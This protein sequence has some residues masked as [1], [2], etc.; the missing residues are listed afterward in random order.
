[1]TDVQLKTA[2]TPEPARMSKVK[3][4]F[5]YV[6]VGGLVALALTAVIA[7]LIGEF[8]EVIQRVMV[9]IF[10]FFAHILFIL[11]VIWA[12]KANQVGKTILPTTVVVLALANMITATLA[13]WDILTAETAWR[14]LGLYFL[15]LA[16][17]FTVIGVLKLRIDQK[18]VSNLTY[19]SAG[20]LIVMTVLLAPWVLGF[21]EVLDP[22]YFRGVG[23]LA[24]VITTAFLVAV[25]FRGI[26]VSRPGYI[27]PIAQL[28]PHVYGGLLAI[29]ITLGVITGMV[30]SVGVIGFITSAVESSYPAGSYS[31][32]SLYDGNY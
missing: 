8:N 21:G 7:L 28:V 19:I 9:T 29:Y 31:N 22:A 18:I 30:M 5:L 14:S 3:V 11:T 10:I 24:I 23:A 32:D 20:L 26:A 2:K 15:I 27:K 25:I 6:L 13:S 1:M 16:T 4:S 17:A 12:D